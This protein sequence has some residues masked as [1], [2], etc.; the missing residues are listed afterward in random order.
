MWCLNRHIYGLKFAIFLQYS[1]SNVL[2]DDIVS[3]CG[4]FSMCESLIA[5]INF[6]FHS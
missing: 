4:V 3:G 1:S 6:I 5:N 2:G